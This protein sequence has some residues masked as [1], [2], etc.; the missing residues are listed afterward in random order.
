MTQPA[1]QLVWEL[2]RATGFVAYLLLLLSVGLGL[3]LSLQ[4]RSERWPRFIGSELHEYLS[5]LA[6]L[7]IGAH[8]LAIAL[9]PFMRFTSAEI[10][11]PLVSHYRPVWMA[12]GIVAT[13][14][15]LAIWFSKRVRA[16][17]GYSWW[18]RF[19]QLTF[20]VYLLTTLHALGMGTDTRTT[21]AG[22]LYAFGFLLV[23]SLLAARLLTPPAPQR[24][25]PY[26]ALLAGVVAVWSLSWAVSG[27][28]AAGWALVANGGAH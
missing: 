26:L 18:L 24:P 11:V 13:Y 10:I 12:W 19:H 22:L 28:L 15:M 16:R 3:I 4:W 21:W 7:A 6:L 17:I 23:T 20:A 14:L 8:T 27:P 25:R 1:S 9:D 5:F 2:A